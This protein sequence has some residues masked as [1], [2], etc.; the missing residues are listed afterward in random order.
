[1][2]HIFAIGGYIEGEQGGSRR[3][4]IHFFTVH[5]S[6][7]TLHSSLFTLHRSQLTVHTSPFT[8]HSSQ[9]TARKHHE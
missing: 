8:V 4:S 7:F 9:F 6:H 5:S 1:M 3:L 2:L